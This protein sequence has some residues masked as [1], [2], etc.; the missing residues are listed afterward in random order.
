MSFPDAFSRWRPHPWHG[1]SAGEDAPEI[2]NAYIEITPYDPVKYETDKQT[3]Y[4]MVDRPQRAS[5]LQPSLYGFVP[6]TYCGKRTA[7]LMGKD[8]LKG[9]KDPLD[10]CVFSER[11][12]TRADIL[13]H[14]RVL[15]GLPMIDDGEADDKIIAVLATDNIWGEARELTDLPEVLIERLDHYF[16][17]YKMLPGKKSTVEIG[18]AYG[19]EHAQKVV[20]ASMADYQER[21]GD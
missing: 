7:S 19:R 15:G 9:D 12:I 18:E 20:K 4:L 16:R 5:S 1:L 14:A 8:G 21:Y 17:T 2:V 11:P 10:I 6:R 3:G 13:L